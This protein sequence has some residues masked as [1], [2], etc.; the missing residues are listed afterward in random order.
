[1]ERVSFWDKSTGDIA[2]DNQFGI[3]DGT[4]PTTVIGGGSIIIH[5]P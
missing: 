1:V 2:Y 3:P 4:D 5:K